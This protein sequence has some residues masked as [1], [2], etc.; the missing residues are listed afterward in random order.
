MD[1]MTCCSF[2]I[3]PVIKDGRVV[4]IVSIGDVV[5]AD[6]R[7]DAGVA[8]AETVHRGQLTALRV[9]YHTSVIQRSNWCMLLIDAFL[10]SWPEQESNL[11]P[12]RPKRTCESP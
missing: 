3:L 4:G 2:A 5:N 1:T 9:P 11:L 10:C 12:L 7:S 8:G 6:R